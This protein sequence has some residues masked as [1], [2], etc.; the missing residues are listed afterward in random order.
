MPTVLHPLL[1]QDALATA[2]PETPT[3]PVGEEGTTATSAP[4]T[5][6]ASETPAEEDPYIKIDSRNIYQ[7]LARLDREN[8]AFRNNLRTFTGRTA[9][10]QYE[11]QL[12]LLKAENEALK[13]AKKQAEILAMPAQTI[14]ERFAKDPEFA[15]DYADA[16]HAQPIDIAARNEQIQWQ[17]A[18]ED[19]FD[20]GLTAGLPPQRVEDYRVALANGHF[21]AEGLSV[22]QQFARM[23]ATMNTEIA[24]MQAAR[25]TASTAAAPVQ[26]DAPVATPSTTRVAPVSHVNP[27]LAEASPDL[28]NA[29]INGDTG[30]MTWSESRQMSRAEQMARWPNWGDF[31]RDVAAGKIIMD[32]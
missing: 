19:V 4:A 31:D 29:R 26:V 2:E 17:Q 27:A 32:A 21:D 11:P 12:E 15:R 28:S 22:P 10:R 5:P 3:N 23:Q 25:A 20:A 6:E 30:V 7:E 16:I 18:I 24:A 9:K 8:E 1:E 13:L 14:E